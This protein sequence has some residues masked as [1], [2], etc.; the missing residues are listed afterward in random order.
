MAG[1][2]TCQCY[3][4]TR[5][6]HTILQPH[7]RPDRPWQT[8][9]I[10]LITGLPGV[11]GYDVIVVYIDHYSKQVHLQV[12]IIPTTSDVDTEGVADIHHREIFCLHGVPTKFI[13]DRR[14]Q[15]A[16]RIMKALYKQLSITHT[17]TTTY[18]PQSNGQMEHANQKVKRHLRLFTNSHHD[19]WVKYLP[20]A[21]FVLNSHRHSAHQMA[22]FKNTTWTS[23]SPQVHQ[24][25]SCP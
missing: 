22:P 18:H 17:L 6:P 1:C 2:D 13:S 21:K 5:H 14:P 24:P 8:V 9:G 15:F 19:D 23:P 16:A 25:N 11:E 4:S 3:K 10:D 20:T 7:N 12:H